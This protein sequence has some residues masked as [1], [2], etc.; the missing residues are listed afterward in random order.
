MKVVVLAAGEGRRLEPLTNRRPKPMIPVA[1][2]PLLEYVLEAVGDAGL[3]EVVLV[4]GYKRER[5]QTY[6][7]DG[8]DW[9]LDVEYAVQEKQ[10]GTGHAI[11]QAEPYVDDD[12]LVLNG[13]GIVERSLVEGLVEADAAVGDGTD[14]VMAVTRTAQPSEYGVVELSGD[15]VTG[16]TEKPRAEESPSDIVN[17]GA[18]AFDQRIFD[19]IRDTE[20][21]DSG[22]LVITDTIAD[23]IADDRVEAIRYD[24]QW[25]DVSHLWDLIQVTADVLDRRGTDVHETAS[26]DGT[27]SVAAPVEIGANSFVGP[28][29]TIARGSAVGQ[30]VTVGAGAILSNAVVLPDATVEPGA[31]L[32]DCVVSENARIGAN[33]TVAGGPADVVVD[34]VVH[35]DVALGAVVGDNA[36]VGGGV[37]VEG[38]TVVGDGVVVEDGATIDGRIDPGVEVRRG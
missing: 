19:A 2:R 21:S 37:V 13:D 8:D 15:R 20:V 16:V 35:E 25:V 9:G 30:N 38:G 29:A 26:V 3:D 1:N 12:F 33:V 4:V 32:R 24:G 7:G 34:G 18:Y 36:D 28:N 10:L 23:L 14:A 31:V 22:E 27:A 5:I 11:L 17:A 6:F